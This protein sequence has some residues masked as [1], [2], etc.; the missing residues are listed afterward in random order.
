[1]IMY[2]TDEWKL[3]KELKI[4]YKNDTIIDEKKTYDAF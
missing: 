2:G 1:M 4:D 3:M